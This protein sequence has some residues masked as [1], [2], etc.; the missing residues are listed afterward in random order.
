M[1]SFCNELFPYLKWDIYSS[2]ATPANIRREF[3]PRNAIFLSKFSAWDTLHNDHRN[4]NVEYEYNT[5]NKYQTFRLCENTGWFWSSIF[6]TLIFVR[7]RDNKIKVI[8]TFLKA[9]I[10][11]KVFFL[12]KNFPSF[13]FANIIAPFCGDGDT[14]RVPMFYFITVCWKS[15]VCR[16]LPDR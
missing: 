10:L 13:F 7:I 16:S 5:R 2:K 12:L 3:H 15:P 6:I 14:A 1:S 4:N 8:F 11:M 9:E